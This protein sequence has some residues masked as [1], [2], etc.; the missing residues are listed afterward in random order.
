MIPP[1]KPPQQGERYNPSN[2]LF[3]KLL[4]ILKDKNPGYLGH[5]VT[6]K[7]ILEKLRGEQLQF[8]LTQQKTLVNILSDAN[9]PN[10]DSKATTI[11]EIL[12]LTKSDEAVNPIIAWTDEHFGETWG[13]QPGWGEDFDPYIAF[14]ALSMIGNE[15]A[16]K[17]LLLHAKKEKGN[18]SS[19]WDALYHLG[20]LEGANYILMEEVGDFLLEF[21][22]QNPD[23]F[24]H[25]ALQSYNKIK[26]GTPREEFSDL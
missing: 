9:I 6:V 2:N 13:E 16:I 12:G 4:A 14:E 21:S 3:D 23:E 20:E 7:T 10:F 19:Q 15:E 11:V 25:C 17:Y 1:I 18:Y 26:H 22:K 24:G 8:D 5:D